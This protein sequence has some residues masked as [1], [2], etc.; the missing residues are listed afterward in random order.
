MNHTEIKNLVEVKN[1]EISLK[2]RNDLQITGV[3]K[4]ESLNP[5]EF[6]V[7]TVLGKMLVK[8]NELSM[9]KLDIEKGILF[10]SGQVNALEYSTKQTKTKSQGF[11]SKLF[12]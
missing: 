7:E 9:S 6:I 5:D 8:G 2:N 11:M 3:T 10:I 1:H 4:L 12:R